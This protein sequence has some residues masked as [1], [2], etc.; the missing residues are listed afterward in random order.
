MDPEVAAR[1]DVFRKLAHDET[2]GVDFSKGLG[3]IATAALVH[4]PVQ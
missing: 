4:C 3:K 2:G 1:V